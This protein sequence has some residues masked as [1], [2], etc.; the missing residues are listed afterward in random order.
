MADPTAMAALTPTVRASP[1]STTTDS[2]SN[3]G[4]TLSSS[5][6]LNPSTVSRP[7]EV[8]PLSTSPASSATGENNNN[9]VPSS[10]PS[11]ISIPIPSSSSLSPPPPCSAFSSCL[12]R[13]IARHRITVGLHNARKL[14]KLL[15]QPHLDYRTVHIAGTNG[16]GS[17]SLKIASALRQGGT[18]PASSNSNSSP[19]IPPPPS[20]PVP[21][22][23]PSVVSPTES[24]S[25]VRVGLF[26]SPHI[27]TVRERITVNG[28]MISEEDFAKFADHI[29]DISDSHGIESSFFEVVT[30]IAFCF[31]RSKECHW[32]V[33]EAGMGGRWDA[34]TIVVPEVCVITSVGWDH[35]Q[36]LGDSLEKIAYE[37]A[38]IIKP[39]TPVVVGPG[40]GLFD[41][42]RERAAQ[43]EADLLEVHVDPRGRTL[44]EEHNEIASLVIV[45]VLRLQMSQRN[46]EEALKVRQPFRMQRLSEEQLTRISKEAVSCRPDTP[47]RQKG[48][49]KED[50]VCGNRLVGM[51]LDVGHNSTAIDRCCQELGYWYFGR[52]VRVIVGLSK[53]RTISVLEPIISHF[54]GTHNKRLKGLHYFDFP[55]PRMKTIADV[56]CELETAGGSSS[57]GQLDP[58]AITTNELRCALLEGLEETEA[59]LSSLRD[60]DRMEADRLLSVL[61]SIVRQC[62][63]EGSLLLMCGSVFMFQSAAPTL[64][65]YN[66]P[67]DPTDTNEASTKTTTTSI[68]SQ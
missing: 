5:S 68:I 56:R 54:N 63:E 7:V 20:S 47:P 49:G 9:T 8:S 27:F 44:D 30:L 26:T 19:P 66:G 53:E 4:T 40:V 28:E 35:M 3:V 18:A 37:K 15:G 61:Y 11:C 32:A 17:V 45:K 16:K 62:I 42:L 59:L 55:H 67:K 34:T 36:I 52:P 24:E 23:S 41:C 31:F 6:L 2:S 33:L 25:I 39:G 43:V 58:S 10:S 60:E 21:P 29:I 50:V 38:G 46:L 22:S 65:L 14:S 48:E 1:P 13:L 57:E 64:G 12:Y 51:I